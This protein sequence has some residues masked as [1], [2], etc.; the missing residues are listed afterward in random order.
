MPKQSQRSFSCRFNHDI[1]THNNNIAQNNAKQ[2]QR[3]K[4]K[5]EIEVSEDGFT[6]NP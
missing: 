2:T 3:L 4:N 6:T 5:M 1:K